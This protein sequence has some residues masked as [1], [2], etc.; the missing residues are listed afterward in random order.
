MSPGSGTRVRREQRLE[1]PQVFSAD[2]RGE[3][4]RLAHAVDEDE[5]TDRDEGDL[6]RFS[7]ERC[8]EKVGR[9]REDEDSS[10]ERVGAAGGGVD[11]AIR[12]AQLYKAETGAD[13]IFYEGFH[14]WEQ[15]ELALKETPGPAYAVGVPL[16]GRKTVA[17]MTKIGQAI[18][19]VAFVLPGVKEVWR[20][21]MQVK[22]SGEATPI[23]EYIDHLN[24]GPDSIGWGALFG[25]PLTDYVRETED[26]FL[27]Q[28]SRRNYDNNVHV[29]ESY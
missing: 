25:R 17:E 11:E 3:A 6:P 10:E 14:T 12:R 23:G 4:L 20:L 21:L 8:R 9:S 27:P 7:A 24:D 18:Q 1:A 13:V 16:I 15:A 26:R 19:P 29:G 22:E 28:E 2:R 5:V